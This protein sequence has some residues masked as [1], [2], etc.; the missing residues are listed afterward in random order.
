MNELWNA[1]TIVDCTVKTLSHLPP[2]FNRTPARVD[3]NVTT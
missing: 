1:H 3:R 2:A